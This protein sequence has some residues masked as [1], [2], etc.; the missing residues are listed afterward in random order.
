[1]RVP[2]AKLLPPNQV[3][4]SAEMRLNLTFAV[5]IHLTAVFLITS[6]DFWPERQTHL[7]PSNTSTS[8]LSLSCGNGSTSKMQLR[9]RIVVRG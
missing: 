5:E 6:H 2:V 3:Y 4:R 1:M 9:Y 7:V 8:E